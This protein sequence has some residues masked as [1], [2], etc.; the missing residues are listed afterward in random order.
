MKNNALKENGQQRDKNFRLNFR[1]AETDLR[2]GFNFGSPDC[3][4][5]IIF[6][7]KQ[8]PST[9]ATNLNEQVQNDI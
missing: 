3:K 5:W 1:I 9:G 2:T 4:K 6:I 8:N 7:G